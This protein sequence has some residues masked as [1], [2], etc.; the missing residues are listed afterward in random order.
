M[1]RGLRGIDAARGPAV[2]SYARMPA[3]PAADGR[4]AVRA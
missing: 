4:I 3:M 2:P 1:A